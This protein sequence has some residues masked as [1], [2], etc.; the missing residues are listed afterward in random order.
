MKGLDFNASL[1]DK[2][3]KLSKA[4]THTRSEDNDDNARLS[5]DSVLS[6]LTPGGSAS[7]DKNLASSEV[8]L[9]RYCGLK[10]TKA[11]HYLAQLQYLLAYHL[12]VRRIISASTSATSTSLLHEE[13]PILWVNGKEYLLKVPNLMSPCGEQ[14]RPVN[15]DKFSNSD[16]NNQTVTKLITNNN[17]YKFPSSTSNYSIGGSTFLNLLNLAES[18]TCKEGRYYRIVCKNTSTP[19]AMKVV[20]ITDEDHME[21]VKQEISLAKRLRGEPHILSLI[22]FE[23]IRNFDS[24]CYIDQRGLSQDTTIKESDDKKDFGVAVIIYESGLCS[25]GD[26]FSDNEQILKTTLVNRRRPR[27]LVSIFSQMAN[28]VNSCHRLGIVHENVTLENFQVIRDSN[29]TSNIDFTTTTGSSVLLK[30]GGFGFCRA[31]DNSLTT[32]IPARIAL[33]RLMLEHEMGNLHYMCP[34][35]VH[36]VNAIISGNFSSASRMLLDARSTSNFAPPNSAAIESADSHNIYSNGINLIGNNLTKNNITSSSAGDSVDNIVE[37]TSSVDIWSLGVCFYHILYGYHPYYAKEP[38]DLLLRMANFKPSSRMF[39]VR[40]LVWTRKTKEKTSSSLQGGKT[41]I[42][43]T[44]CVSNTSLSNGPSGPTH[45]NNSAVVLQEHSLSTNNTEDSSEVTTTTEPSLEDTKPPAVVLG[46]ALCLSRENLRLFDTINRKKK[47]SE[48][49]RKA[50]RRPFPLSMNHLDNLAPNIINNADDAKTTRD[51]RREE[52]GSNSSSTSAFFNF[53]FGN[54]NANRDSE[55][56]SNSTTGTSSAEELLLPGEVV[57]SPTTPRTSASKPSPYHGLVS[58]P[59]RSKNNTIQ[60]QSLPSPYRSIKGDYINTLTTTS[61]LSRNNCTVTSS[62]SSTSLSV[63]G[64]LNMNN[65]IILNSTTTSNGN[66][67]PGSGARTTNYFSPNN[68]VLNLQKPRRP[69]K[70]YWASSSTTRRQTQ[71][72]RSLKEVHQ[73]ILDSKKGSESSIISS[74]D[75]NRVACSETHCSRTPLSTNT[76]GVTSSG[77]TA[78]G[79]PQRSSTTSNKSEKFKKPPDAAVVLLIKNN[80]PLTGTVTNTSNSTNLNNNI[81]KPSI[82]NNITHNKKPSTSNCA[83]RLSAA[84]PTSSESSDLNGR[85]TWNSDSETEEE[86]LIFKPLPTDIA[87]SAVFCGNINGPENSD[88]N[89]KKST[90]TTT[91]TTTAVALSNINNNANTTVLNTTTDSSTKSKYGYSASLFHKTITPPRDVIIVSEE[92]V[93]VSDQE[94]L[95][96][97]EEKAELEASTDFTSN[98]SSNC[99]FNISNTNYADNVTS[100]TSKST[101]SSMIPSAPPLDSPVEPD[102]YSPEKSESEALFPHDIQLPPARGVVLGLQKINVLSLGGGQNYYHPRHHQGGPIHNNSSNNKLPFGL[103]PIPEGSERSETFSGAT[104]LTDSNS[105]R[106][107]ASTTKSSSSLLELSQSSSKSQSSSSKTNDDQILEDVLKLVKLQ[108]HH[109]SESD[110]ANC[111]TNSKTPNSKTPNSKSPNSKTP[112]SKTPNSKTSNSKSPNSK[113]TNSTTST[114][115]TTST[116]STKINKFNINDTRTSSLNR[117]TSANASVTSTKST[118]LSNRGTSSGTSSDLINT[119]TSTNN[120]VSSTSSSS[121]SQEKRNSTLPPL[122]ENLQGLNSFETLQRVNSN[123]LKKD[124]SDTGRASVINYASME[125]SQ[126]DYLS[127]LLPNSGQPSVP[128]KSCT[129]T[130]N[131]S[132]STSTNTKTSNTSDTSINTK[133]I[134]TATANTSKNLNSKNAPEAELLRNLIAITR[135]CLLPTEQH[136][137]AASEV[138]QM[139][140]LV[141]NGIISSSQG[142]SRLLEPSDTGSGGA[143]LGNKTTSGSTCATNL[144][145]KLNNTGNSTTTTK[146]VINNNG[147]T[148]VVNSDINNIEK[149]SVLSAHQQLNSGTKENNNLTTI[150]DLARLTEQFYKSLDSNTEETP[151]TSANLNSKD[152]ELQRTSSSI[153]KQLSEV[154]LMNLKSNAGSETDEDEFIENHLTCSQEVVVTRTTT[155]LDPLEDLAGKSSNFN[156]DCSSTSAANLSLETIV[157]LASDDKKNDSSITS[158]SYGSI[159]LRK[160]VD[161]VRRLTRFSCNKWSF[162]YLSLFALFLLLVLILSLS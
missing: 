127:K 119:V 60:T 122:P 87:P 28:A 134:S 95:S 136:R 85:S 93:N 137:L 143:V 39:R 89:I 128:V 16:V 34:Q 29:N 114:R 144:N 146:K 161:P 91:T 84:T 67:N 38:G 41:T 159:E 23:I 116:N 113:S 4:R 140:A 64:N 97:L 77:S 152:F 145:V 141:T 131:V 76:G 120:T 12:K 22:D 157:I 51:R 71:F 31:F 43:T 78:S 155:D 53:K 154:N 99:K 7:T 103:A 96:S 61:A 147:V 32:R 62:T 37:L 21:S 98:T 18:L 105:C 80:S 49:K 126:V 47:I 149:T 125:L 86:S 110:K 111:K 90:G 20:T 63:T 19:Y 69:L 130:S 5:C 118:T 153:S 109:G 17:N 54:S 14:K 162:L 79:S 104:T 42:T 36:G 102:D 45:I 59:L 74:S 83:S 100:T 48:L 133:T 160:D 1:F 6:S 68:S 92:S 117:L 123:K 25:L 75:I 40:D 33:M 148:G 107:A 55:E 70:N 30:L 26:Y 112:N 24:I 108:H 65:D 82:S 15:I 9:D 13:E 58:N 106:C 124:T 121:R 73:R 115:S 2:L 138:L 151:D 135:G 27:N 94:P 35:M 56:A 57:A 150:T 158:R 8:E 142:P 129:N 139:V 3:T 50:D 66:L 46:P 156:L 72:E 11:D 10:K 101:T 132:E 52:S 88:L 44:A 81:N